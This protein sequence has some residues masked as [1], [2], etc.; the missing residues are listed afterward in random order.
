M[1]RHN[2]QVAAPFTQIN[3]TPLLDITFTLLIAFMIIAPALK[4]GIK[5]DLPEVKGEPIREKQTTLTI[6]IQKRF[7]GETFER[8]KLNGVR[9]TLKDLEEKLHADYLSRKDIDVILESDKDV[10]WDTIL[11]VV[12]AVTRAGIDRTGFASEP[13]PKRKR[14]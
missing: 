3:L 6:I 4:H 7:E 10:P 2:K 1:K 12:G 9:I 14:R 8:I 13:E 5:M 11:K